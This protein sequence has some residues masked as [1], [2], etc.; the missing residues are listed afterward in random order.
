MMTRKP[1]SA[2]FRA[3]SA[4]ASGVRCAERTRCSLAM[5]NSLSVSTQWRIVSQSDLLPIMTATSGFDLIIGNAQEANRFSCGIL[6]S[7][8][9]LSS[10]N[11]GRF[12]NRHS[13]LILQGESHQIDCPDWDDG[14]GQICC[15][16]S[17]GTKNRITPSRHGRNNFIE[18][19]NAD[20]GNLF[21]PRRGTLSWSGNGNIALDVPGRTSNYR[22]RGR[23]R[24]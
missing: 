16:K 3:K 2:P 18:V 20:Q 9:A 21:D 11:S 7:K 5:P 12:G 17:F 19:K 4:V 22:Y 1:R 13:L 6:A 10:A 15:R 14:N 23:Y 8:R 24:T